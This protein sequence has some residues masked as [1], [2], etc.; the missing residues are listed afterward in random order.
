[1][2][3]GLTSDFE[4]TINECVDQA[5]AYPHFRSSLLNASC[6]ICPYIYLEKMLVLLYQKRGQSCIYMSIIYL[7]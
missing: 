3:I 6:H 2:G 4:K 7:Q 1:M 5:A